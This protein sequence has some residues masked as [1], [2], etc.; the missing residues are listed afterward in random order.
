MDRPDLT[1]SKIPLVLIGLMADLFITL[2]A[3]AKWQRQN[4]QCL[5]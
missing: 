1:V 4:I 5:F 2:P 3:Q